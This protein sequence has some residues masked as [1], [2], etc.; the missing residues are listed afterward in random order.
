[1]AEKNYP[2][3]LMV[4]RKRQFLT[5]AG[6][7]ALTEDVAKQDPVR[8][9]QISAR[10]L[11]RLERGECRPLARTAASLAKALEVD[12]NEIFPLGAAS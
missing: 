1:V 12:P 7:A 8:F 11:D 10:S 5:R 9:L 3:N 4:E 2:N 6:L